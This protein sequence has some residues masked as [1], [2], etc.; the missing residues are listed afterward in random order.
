MRHSHGVKHR[1][2]LFMSV[3]NK[4]VH[5]FRRPHLC[6]CFISVQSQLSLSVWALSGRPHHYSPSLSH[7]SVFTLFPGNFPSL[8]PHPPPPHPPPPHPLRLLLKLTFLST[9][10]YLPTCWPSLPACLRQ[11]FPLCAHTLWVVVVRQNSA[12]TFPT[13]GWAT[14]ACF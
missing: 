3:E 11:H 12:T 2:I 4:S 10:I 7:S 9:H 8:V 1:F 5:P 14:E 6:V 13:S